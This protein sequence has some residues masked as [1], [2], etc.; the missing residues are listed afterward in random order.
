MNSLMMSLQNWWSQISAR[1]QRLV[2][3]CAVLLV[4]GTLYWGVIQPVSQRAENA[5]LRIQSEKQLL[6][7]VQDK[8]DEIAS[9]R[10]QNGQVISNTPMNQAISSTAGRFGVELI[11][12]QPRD[13]QLQVWITPLPFN[14]LV[15]W[16]SFLQDTHGISVTFLDIDKGDQNGVVEV[17]RLQFTKG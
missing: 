17:K 15:E 12:V 3:V 11:R 4:L 2:V 7:W 16:M 10:G 13:E 1:E 8:A 6:S 14:R 5:Q 9:L